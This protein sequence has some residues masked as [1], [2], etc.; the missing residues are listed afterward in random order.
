MRYKERIVQEDH[1]PLLSVF[2][3]YFI[4][5]WTVLFIVLPIGLRTQDDEG[6]VALGTVASAPSS[7]K[8]GRIVLWTTLISAL[9]CGIWY[10]GTWWFGVSLD[11]LPR[12]IPVFD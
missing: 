2:A 11:D 10:G 3:V 4:V 6:D 12:I 7:F 1:M 9:I 8:G 5:W